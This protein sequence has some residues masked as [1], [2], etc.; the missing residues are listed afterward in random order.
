M[1]Q[2][3]DPRS[4]SPITTPANSEVLRQSKKK[5]G[6]KQHK[7]SKWRGGHCRCGRE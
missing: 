5:K 1:A 3:L 6:C 4:D 2:P 7:C